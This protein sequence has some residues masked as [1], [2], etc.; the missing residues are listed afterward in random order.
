[1]ESGRL[2]QQRFLSGIFTGDQ[3]FGGWWRAIRDPRT[4]HLRM[5]HKSTGCTVV[6]KY[7]SGHSVALDSLLKQRER[8]KETYP[9]ALSQAVETELVSDLGSVH[10]VLYENQRQHFSFLQ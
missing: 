10:G 5:W 2:Y 3:P 7:V 1:M 8:K 6:G 4:D 9:G